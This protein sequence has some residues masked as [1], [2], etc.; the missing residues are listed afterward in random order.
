MNF[1]NLVNFD[2]SKRLPREFGGERVYVTARSDIRVLKPGWNACAYDLQLVV[3]HIVRPGMC[4]W[5]IGAN[6]GILSVFAAY[7]VGSQGAVYALEADP[8]YA[9][10]IFRSSRRLSTAYQPISVLC[11][12]IAD[13]A[14]VLEFGVAKQGHARNK[15]LHLAD[16][17]FEL[18]SRKMVPTLRGDDLLEHWRAP[19]FVKMDVEGA[20]LAA[21]QGSTKLLQT[22][23]PIFYIEVSPEN[24]S[25][26]TD[27]FR[28]CDY[29][30]F[31]LQGDATER[32]V[33]ECT[34]YTVARPRDPAV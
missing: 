4:V 18:E 28:S 21:L 8:V 19:D 32:P 11:A 3:R 31:H 14:G 13:H 20:E 10:R 9:D 25:A 1:R 12:A 27:L 6:L 16:E 33:E 30:I 15:L 26:V 34:F 17:D 2:F 5:D 22:A 23:R 7:R 29:D 24:Q